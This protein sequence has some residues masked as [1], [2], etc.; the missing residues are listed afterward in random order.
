MDEVLCMLSCQHL[1]Q[2]ILRRCSPIHWSLSL[3]TAGQQ[4]L[5]QQHNQQDSNHVSRWGHQHNADH[6]DSLCAVF[7]VFFKC[8]A[9]AHCN[10]E[11]LSGP[12][13]HGSCGQVAGR[14]QSNS[15][16]LWSN[17]EYTWVLRLTWTQQHS[18]LVT[19]PLGASN[20]TKRAG[21]SM[22]CQNSLF[23]HHN[24]T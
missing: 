5:L 2:A 3:C 7:S 14:R 23:E 24:M 11:D 20:D 16:T 9:V 13:R 8:L 19:A 4:I 10:A 18:G 1:V 21:I 12:C 22:I 15:I 17:T 6:F